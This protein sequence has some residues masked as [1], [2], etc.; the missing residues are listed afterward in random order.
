[1][2]TKEDARPSPDALLEAASREGRGHLKVFLGAAPGVGKTYAMLEAARERR[3]DGSDVVAAVVET[4]GRSE[5]AALLQGLETLPPRVLEHRGR[6]FE[7]MDLDAVLA[8]RPDLVLV[9]E[10]AHTNVP[11]SR[12][13]KRW[14]DVEEILAAGIDVYSTLNVQHLESLNDVVE[15][16][17]GV[18]VRETLPDDALQRA[19]EI[20]LIDLPPQDLLRR[21]RE[22]KIYLPEQARRAAEHFFS[23][24]NLTA[25]REL[26]L[27]SAADRVDA[28][29]LTYMRSHAIRGPWPAR[30]RIMACLGD[31]RTALRIVRTARRAAERRQAPWLAVYVETHRHHTLPEAAKDRIAEALRLAEQL[32]GEATVVHGEDVAAELL[33]LARAR[34]VSQIVVGHVPKFRPLF[35]WPFSWLRGRST[36]RALLE[37]AAGIDVLVVTGEEDGQTAWPARRPRPAASPAWR[38]YATAVAA[39]AVATAIGHVL[40][41]Y[42]AL[43]DIS[44]VYLLAV[45]PVAVRHGLRPSI[46][47]SLLG[48]LGLNFFFT[49]PLYTFAVS[50]SGNVLTIVFFLVVAVVTSNLAARVRAQVEATRSSARRTAALYDFSR[51]VASAATRDDVLWAIVH[52]VAAVARGRSLVLLP[53]EGGLAVEAGYPPEDRIDDKSMAAAEWAWAHEEPA[54]R[55]SATLPSSDWL[56]RPLRTGR[57]AIGVL[58]IRTEGTAAILPPEEER[59]LA[60]LADQ[61]ALAIERTT[62]VSD[63]E[64][65]RIATERERLRAALLSSLSHDLRTPL[66]S[67]LGAASSLTTLGAT[68]DE[69]SR[70]ELARTI[71]DEAERLNR[72]VQN[73]LDMTRLGSGALRPRTDWVD[74]REVVGS[75]LERAAKLP[76]PRRVRLDIDPAL[77]LLRLDPV[78]MEQVLFNLLDNA[79]KYAPPETP[80]TV[81]ARL[82]GDNA[83]L[84]VCDQGPGIPPEA[85][86]SVFDMF[87]RVNAGDSRTAGTG[88]GLAICRGIVE[89]HGGSISA[90]P[91]LHGTGTCIV[92]TLPVHGT[93]GTAEATQAP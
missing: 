66:V 6:T 23:P 10:L 49:E 24:G 77:P 83:V 5:T 93:D 35:P 75:A 7:E 81:W 85:R 8:R 40:D 54:G 65:A 26:A 41:R 74:L 30:E 47:A 64:R 59:L 79:R 89:A 36:A 71:Q 17:T 9:D 44:L 80:V 82:R 42:L 3:R 27:R 70:H 60:A 45:L 12:H 51:K 43:P 72:F 15:R 55:G 4:H 63:V 28:Q 87:Y 16:I 86:E 2:G 21:L 53:R 88:L 68:L 13:P 62:L 52:H 46:F 29:M 32:G 14:Q 91:G 90:Q 92:V 76:G 67:I 69:D 73:L 57:G 37:R 31:D 1:M 78:L 50:D 61:A 39:C 20:E 48:F 56:F 38:G 33:D 11:G 25:L 19:D 84:E 22:G 18:R 34:N 58:G